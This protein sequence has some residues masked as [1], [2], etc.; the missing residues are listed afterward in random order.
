MIKYPCIFSHQMEATVYIE[1]ALLVLGR[2]SIRQRTG[3]RG[4]G[5]E[6]LTKI[7]QR[8]PNKYQESV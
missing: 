7:L 6:G 2:T 3:E 1:Q 4:R 5:R 8:I